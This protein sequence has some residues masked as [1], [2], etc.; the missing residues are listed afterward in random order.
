MA[1]APAIEGDD[2]YYCAAHSSRRVWKL[3][4]SDGTIVWQAPEDV[5]DH[6][7][8][9]PA[10][11]TGARAD[12]VYQIF[13]KRIYALDKAD[14]SIIWSIQD[15]QYGQSHG[16]A[17]YSNSRLY[18]INWGTW[19]TAL[20]DQGTTWSAVYSQQFFD[21]RRGPVSLFDTTQYGEIMVFGS[22]NPGGGFTAVTAGGVGWSL[23]WNTAGI[24]STD[25]CATI[26]S[27]NNCY[28]GVD[29]G[30]LPAL[31]SLDGLTGSLNWKAALSTQ[32][33]HARRGA[34]ALS[35]D[36]TRIYYQWMGT[37]GATGELVALSTQDGSIN[38]SLP[39]GLSGGGD[40]APIASVI[41][42]KQG[43]I[44]FQGIEDGTNIIYCVQDD[45]ASA[46]VMWTKAC[47]TLP[48]SFAI[49]QDG[50]LYF[51]ANIA[52][53]Q[54]CFKIKE[55]PPVKPQI[56]DMSR[57]SNVKI[58]FTS[59]DETTYRVE[60]SA[61]PY[62]YDESNM[63]WATIADGIPGQAH[64]T[65]W[66]DTS[67]PTSGEK[68]YRVYAKSVAFD[69]AKAD[70]T[71]GLM[72][73]SMALG[74]N[75]AAS[76]FLP[77]PEGVFVRL[78]QGINLGWTTTV[79][80]P[81]GDAIYWPSDDTGTFE[82]SD[83]ARTHIYDPDG[84]GGEGPGW[85]D[86]PY[87]DFNLAG[88]G[89]IDISQGG[90]FEVDCRYY[91]DPITNTNPYGD[92]PIFLCMYDYDDY[93]TTL[94]GWR[95]FGI[96]YATQQGDAPHPTWTHKIID[97]SGGTD[98]NDNGIFDPASV[99]Y[100]R[101]YGTDW[102]GG[103]DDFIDVKNVKITLF[104]VEPGKSTLDKI[105][106]DQL[107]GSA[108]AQFFSDNIEKWD[109]S[110]TNYVRAWNDTTKWVD[111]DTVSDPPQFGFD[112]DVGYWVNILAFNPPKDVTVFG[113]VAGTGG[114]ALAPGDRSI[115]IAVGR[116]L[117]GVSFPTARPFSQS[118]LVTSGFTGS[119]IMFFS[120][121][122]E[123]WDNAAGNY[124]RYWYDTGAGAWTAW[125]GGNPLRDIRAGE[126][127]W[128]TVLAFNSSFTW[129]IPV[130]PGGGN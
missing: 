115:P 30:G 37:G 17:P 45:G 51:G 59:D 75:L 27:T 16:I 120:D 6:Y 112:A 61:D 87:V 90:T 19:V 73:L 2:V 78:D 42:D 13:T 105:I 20:E 39:N 126:G 50:G 69:D 129:T 117:V 25:H 32:T 113:K 101:L 41:A 35:Y 104:S 49:G 79:D 4:G 46:S 64:T 86:G 89:S 60:A 53:T 98:T 11:G 81:N 40:G 85:Y 48:S 10:I 58:S 109:N 116:N 44:Y 56:L 96:F 65:T 122:V 94:N 121:T 29:D 14:G 18:T 108:F 110:A 1:L 36:Q 74:R 123:L 114:G 5:G 88:I 82:E 3:N 8:A 97:L 99:D 91:Q 107:T 93:G 76:P 34:G 80:S 52:G 118:N 103:G 43:K 54:G 9:T 102:S 7:T 95:D 71:V 33:G 130:P 26:D 21:V 15:G 23:L 125:T 100:I 70:D 62:D 124:D 119:T 72:I 67:T 38:W 128:V 83:Y 68:Y 55:S 63:T 84:P 106:G 24:G 77:Y 28:W 47:T 127:L 12:R 66:E 31:V 92:A 57:G 22:R 111:W